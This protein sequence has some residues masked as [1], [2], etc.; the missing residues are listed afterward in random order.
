MKKHRLTK[1]LLRRVE[2]MVKAGMMGKP[3][4]YRAMKEVS[5]GGREVGR[6]PD[7]SMA[8]RPAAFAVSRHC[9]VGGTQL[10]GVSPSLGYALPSPR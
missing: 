4:W 2:P 5:E 8:V 6:A 9:C 3:K 1:S 10:H 7:R